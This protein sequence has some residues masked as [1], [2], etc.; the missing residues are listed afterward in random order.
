[1]NPTQAITALRH[2]ITEAEQALNQRIGQAKA[3]AEQGKA[4]QAEAA[5]AEDLAHKYSAACAL[6][7]TFADER[8]Q[9]IHDK[10]TT[11]VSEGLTKIFQEDLRLVIHTKSVGKRVDT[12]FRL[13]TS[14]GDYDVETEILS[15]RGGGVAAV[16]GFLLQVIMILLTDS[17]RVLFLDESF[18]QVSAEYELRLAEFL[19]ELS[20]ELGMQIV[21]V[22]HSN[23]YEEASQRVYRVSAKNGSTHLE[24]VK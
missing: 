24:K 19:D 1:M 15:A 21:L 14:Y 7:S 11:L 3:I 12:E 6:L 9:S 17:P 4:F 8:Q 20:Q 22:T 13:L 10:L 16:T 5:T 18:A 2:R 23:A